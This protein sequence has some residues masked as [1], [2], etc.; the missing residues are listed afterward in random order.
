MNTKKTKIMHFR[1]GS[2]QRSN[3]NFKINDVILE[4]VNSYKYLGV[5]MDENVKYDLAAKTITDSA[6]RALGS[7][8]NKARTYK[9]IGSRTFTTLYYRCVTPVMC[10]GA[11]IWGMNKEA[12]KLCHNIQK[13]AIRFF[14]GV[15][16]FTPVDS[17]QGDM[18]WTSIPTTINIEILRLWNRMVNTK[19]ETTKLTFN[20][21]LNNGGKWSRTVQEIMKSIGLE[22]AFHNRATVNLKVCTELMM[23][24]NQREWLTA[25]EQKPKLRSYV[26]F[27][28]EYKMEKY[29]SFNFTKYE[30]SL[31]AQ[32]RSGILP[33]RIEVGRYRQEPLE[34]R[35]C[36]FCTR[37][38]IE[39]EEHFIFDCPLYDEER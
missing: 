35:V 11:G 2:N 16:R 37:N 34:E 39:D 18:G 27:K 30:R 22:S 29:I 7:V 25:C 26:R 33:L 10:Y 24:N 12:M 6:G 13:R 17:M 1:R 20:Y 38:D 8:I 19:I 9:D 5:I 36:D 14:L 32:F 4:Y 31:C 21:D 28:H 3:Y 15:H 23:D